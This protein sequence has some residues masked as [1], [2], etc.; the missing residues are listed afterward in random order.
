VPFV[1][2]ADAGRRLAEQ[3][4]FP[5]D[6]DVVVLG[7]PRGG[8]AVAAEVALALDAPL[9]VVVVRKI[10]LPFQPELA[11]GAVG[12]EGI[13]IVND[14]V[15][16]GARVSNDDFAEVERRERTE[17]ERRSQRF[18]LERPRVSLVGRTAVVV[19][20]G[21]ATGST[22]KVACE[23]ARRLGAARVVLAVPVAPARSVHELERVAD[24]VVCIETPPSFHS[25]GQW[26]ADFSQATDD[27]VVA[28]LRQA[29]QRDAASLDRPS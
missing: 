16:Q 10:G 18:R 28:L 11:M 12:E 22:A 29:A 2:R 21:I 25:V 19:D 3:L 1:D 17:L 14:D 5:E 8:V 27:E 9:D 23:V 26:Y 4:R 24:E 6:D 20:D 7:L 13:R 15:V